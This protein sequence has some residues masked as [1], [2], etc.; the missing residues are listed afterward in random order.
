MEPARP[1]PRSLQTLAEQP[2]SRSQDH[3]YST[4]VSIDTKVD[5]D[6]TF[7]RDEIFS[8]NSTR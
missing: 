6:S 5:V 1:N 4:T 2:V 8:A 7:G 3:G